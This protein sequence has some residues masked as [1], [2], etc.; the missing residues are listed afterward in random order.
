MLPTKT[1]ANHHHHSATFE[2]DPVQEPADHQEDLMH[3][4]FNS[5]LSNITDQY[6][7]FREDIA[8]KKATLPIVVAYQKNLSVCFL[9]KKATHLILDQLQAPSVNVR[10]HKSHS[11]L[12]RKCCPSCRPRKPSGPERTSGGWPSTLRSAHT[13]RTCIVQVSARATLMAAWSED[14]SSLNFAR[15]SS[16]AASLSRRGYAD[17]GSTET[18]SI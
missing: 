9:S 2:D 15:S 5:D 4:S 8:T 13:S 11:S 17:M 7:E 6:E 3:S 14:N 16:T 1:T 18:N 12:C 10:Q